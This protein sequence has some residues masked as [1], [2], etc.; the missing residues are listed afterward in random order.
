MKSQ[1][2]RAF[3]FIIILSVFLFIGSLFSGF[4]IIN[5][6]LLGILPW[7]FFLL[8]VSPLA[9]LFALLLIRPSLDRLSEILSFPI[10][11]DSERFITIAQ[12][13]G[14]LT[15]ILGILYLLPKIK[16]VWKIPLVFPFSLMLLWGIGTFS[17][18]INISQTFYEILRLFSIFFIFLLAY[19]TVN[20][21]KK[22]LWLL[23]ASIASAFVPIITGIYQF[24]F[25]IGYVDDAFSIPRIYGTFAATNI[26]ALYLVVILAMILLLF[27][28]VKSKE[29]KFFS[30]MVFFS[31]FIILFLTYSRAAW[32]S[33]FAF[34]GVL[35]LVKYP[36]MLPIL[37]IL[38]LL[39]FALSETVQDRVTEALTFTPYSSLM[40]RVT[41]WNDTIHQTFSDDKTLFGYGLN[42][43]EIV[44]E[45]IR[46]DRFN[47]NAPHSE[48][49]RSF[50]E[51]GIVGLLVFLFFS[52]APVYV[53]WQYWQKNK[54]TVSGDIFLLLGSLCIALLLLSFTDHVLRS[55]MVQWILWA[56]LGG[57]LRVYGDKKE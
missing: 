13:F 5:S 39:L 19:L 17:Y 4:S 48:F 11:F 45:N 31:T 28:L 57:A 30:L 29:A 3:L 40:S 35:T 23:L 32:A 26:F 10:P 52:F 9:L 53:L 50:V 6:L 22:F 37:I 36:K 51:G 47:V 20:T 2:F 7:P 43:F 24:I 1:F 44:A 12:A 38:P 8:F 54:N 46:G 15:V 18:S 41:I 16:S 21:H 27:F 55:T 34:L 49:V 25:N 14:L 42:T 56:V 33:F